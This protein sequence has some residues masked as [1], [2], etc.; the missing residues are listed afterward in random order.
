MAKSKR[1][2]N[3]VTP[4][5]RMRLD[6]SHLARVSKRFGLGAKLSVLVLIGMVSLLSLFAY[7]GT[8]ALE[9]NIQ[10]TMHERVILAQTT[11]SHIDYSIAS[12]ENILT[13]VANE[14]HW[15]NGSAADA[16]LLRAYRHLGFFASRVFM[17]DQN[18]RFV[19]AYPPTAGTVSLADFTPVAEVL[20][21]Q[22]F[23]ISRYAQPRSVC[24]SC[25]LA[26]A[27]VRD[28]VGNTKGALAIDI[29]I[30]HPNI[31][32]FSHPIGLGQT[33]YMD[34]VALD[35]LI[36]ASTRPERVGQE[37]DHGYSLVGMIR[38]HRQSVSAC[39]DCHTS[40]AQIV[41]R[42]EVLAFAPLDRAQWGVAV[43]QSEDEV[44][45]DIRLLQ[46]RIFGLMGLAILG[47]LVLVYLT[48]RSVLAPIQ[49]LT[50]ATR[51]IAA[52]D[53]GTPIGTHG[54]DEIE[55]L[56]QS[57]DAM[58][59]RLDS[60]MAEIQA[61]NRQLD[62]RVQERT[63][64]L[65]QALAENARLY[66]ELARKEHLRGELLHRLI[67]AQE[68]ERKRI[69]RELH[70]ETCQVLTGLAYALDEAADQDT[71]P[72]SQASL[73]QMRHLTDTAL[74]SIHRIIFDLRPTMLDHLGLIP[75]IRWYAE[76]RLAE[77]E[78]AFNIREIGAPC[79][80]PPA[81]ETAL[82]RVVQEA[83]N[84]IARHAKAAHALFVFQFAEDCVEAR[85]ADDGQGFD[86]GQ[87]AAGPIDERGLGLVGMEERMSAIGGSFSIRSTPGGGTIVKL[88]VPIERKNNGQDP[89]AD[90][91]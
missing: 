11:A 23:A 25:I 39:H 57:F 13:Q 29:D 21:G 27:P 87:V 88:R 30:T 63:R 40:P 18:G 19:A 64:E 81:V 74:D 3:S 20:N 26:V 72:R 75:A 51:R 49:V 90:R 15:M 85:I 43:H 42:N 65:E 82:F 53:L 83:I 76:Q 31:R 22:S 41:P 45:A 89:S 35:G 44:F 28:S 55:E 33:G 54:Q 46:I 77:P 7:L 50:A 73:E 78:T 10:R 8:K 61:L 6:C 47:A 34:L 86:M 56:T 12:A 5:A 4:A 1:M 60:S 69:S 38:D 9:E 79:R 68:E 52:G 58:R 62:A 66:A 37:S 84:N 17:L 32:A 67:S 24:A 36:L 91:G 80:L 2:D 16:A 48:T 71:E 14:E 59:S 70:D